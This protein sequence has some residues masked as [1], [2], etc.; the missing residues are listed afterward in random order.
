MANVDNPSGFTP[1]RYLSGAPYNGAT[2]RYAI[3]AADN[4]ATF[5]GDLVK[6]GGSATADGVPSVV[7]ATAG[8]TNIAG[9]VVGFEIDPTDLTLLYRAAS[10][11]RY[12]LVSDDP[13]V[14]YE[15]QE[16]SDVAALTVDEVGENC[17]IIVGSGNT[18]SGIS[19]ME[20][21]SNTHTA[22]AANVRIIRL[23]PREDNAIGNYAK[24][25]V[26]INEHCYK[27]T[28]GT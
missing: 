23:V 15:A 9:A 6:I 1:V 3:L 26:L 7:Q 18:T 21:D 12:A 13:Y 28:S 27:T 10:T 17:D 24:W 8:A 20:I 22:N 14:L 4:T 16:D 19:A 11:L 2:N 25:E 5:V